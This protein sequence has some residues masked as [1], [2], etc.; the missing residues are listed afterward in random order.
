[1]AK[2]A[3]SVELTTD[4]SLLIGGELVQSDARLDVVNPALGQVFAR[5]RDVRSTRAAWKSCATEASIAVIKLCA[6]EAFRTMSFG[7]RRHRR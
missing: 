3:E 4:F 2:R 6:P 5:A 7:S 1:M